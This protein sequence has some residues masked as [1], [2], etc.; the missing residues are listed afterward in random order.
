MMIFKKL[1]LQLEM[2][3]QAVDAVRY[4]TAKHDWLTKGV[5]VSDKDRRY[6][7]VYDFMLGE[8]TAIKMQD[9]QRFKT[10]FINYLTHHDLIRAEAALELL[11]N[12]F[13]K[14][15]DNIK[16]LLILK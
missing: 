6:F 15:A 14:D 9:K 4:V 11:E 3:K 5:E 1:A 8:L 10:T 2:R 7:Q 12:E 13:Q 16:K